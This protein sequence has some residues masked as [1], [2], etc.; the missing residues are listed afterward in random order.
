MPTSSILPYLCPEHFRQIPEATIGTHALVSFRTFSVKAV[1]THRYYT[2]DIEGRCSTG[3]VQSD[4][5]SVVSC[6]LCTVIKAFRKWELPINQECLSLSRYF[7][8][9]KS[10]VTVFYFNRFFFG[11]GG[12]SSLVTSSKQNEKKNHSWLLPLPSLLSP[13]WLELVVILRGKTAGTPHRLSL[14]F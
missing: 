13:L 1:Q 7:Q 8:Q 11:G 4:P 6:L 14:T 10:T 12:G 2:S 5:P 3:A 9:T